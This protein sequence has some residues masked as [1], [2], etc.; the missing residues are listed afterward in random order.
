[1]DRLILDHKIRVALARGK[2][3]FDK[4]ETIKAREDKRQLDRLNKTFKVR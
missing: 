4:R 1:M 2:K 3:A